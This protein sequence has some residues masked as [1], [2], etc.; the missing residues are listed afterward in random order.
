MS[1][2]KILIVDDEVFFRRL[3]TEIL[4][5]GDL[6]DIDTVDS[7]KEALNYLTRNKVDVVL[8]DMV[9]PEI[10]GLELVRRTRSFDPAPDII[11][12]TGNATVET[13][14]QALKGGARDYLLKPCNPEQLRHTVKTCLEQRRL[15]AENSLLQ[16]QIRLYRK[17]QHLSGQL[18]IDSLFQESL[19]SLLYEFG[20]GCGLA[21]LSNQN[22]ISHISNNGLDDEQ[23]KQLAEHLVELTSTMEHSQLINAADYPQIAKIFKELKSLWVFPLH[24]DDNQ[25]GALVVCNPDGAE[26][27]ETTA[28]ENMNFLAE[29]AAL[30]FGNACQYQGARELIYTDDLTGLY[31]HRYL[32]IA[33][34]QEMRRSE[35]YGL[36]FSLAFV[37]LDLFK[38]I[39][40]EHGHL[41]G[42]GVLRQIGDLLRECVRDADMLFRYGGDEFTAL[43]VETDT[44]GAKIVAERIR[45]SV[46]EFEF[47]LGEG[48]TGRLTAT[49]GHATYPIHATTKKEMIDLADKAM[50]LGKDDRNVARSASEV[51]DK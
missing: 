16:S 48:K 10:C 13:A 8:S 32:H 7:G 31:N 39:N 6:Y 22:V 47:A 12:A 14:I 28:T 45:S 37:D 9:M 24:S 21:F 15:I 19:S 51:R 38:G 43:L 36:E 5:E 25:H 46:E 50:Y 3:F 42:S 20:D 35:R 33:L 30:G 11:L 27:P 41:V 40:D 17:G 1:K 49:V 23:A 34:E 29:Q 4:S 18:D 26:K 2:P 44:R